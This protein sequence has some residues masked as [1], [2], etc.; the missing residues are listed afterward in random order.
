MLYETALMMLTIAEGIV[1]IAKMLMPVFV[2]FTL[3]QAAFNS[4]KIKKGRR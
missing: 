2:I 3:G 4:Y 1:A